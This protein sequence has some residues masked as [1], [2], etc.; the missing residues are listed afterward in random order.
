MAEATMAQAAKDAAKL[1]LAKPA[2]K[3]RGPRRPRGK[4]GRPKGSKNKK[5]GRPK[6][7][8][9]RGRPKG[10]KN[11]RVGR[12]KG[13]TKPG[14]KPGVLKGYVKVAEVKRIAKAAAAKVKATLPKLIRRE[15]LKLLK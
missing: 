15:L 8:G 6:G 7:S 5:V 10:S 4:R 13:S 1:D 12:P 14:R 11:K 3:K 9:K 2:K